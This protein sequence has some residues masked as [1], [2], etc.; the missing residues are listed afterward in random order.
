MKRSNLAFS[1]PRWLKILFIASIMIHLSFWCSI[2]AHF[3]RGTTISGAPLILNGQGWDY[4]FN[5]TTYRAGPASDFFQIVQ[6]GRDLRDGKSIYRSRGSFTANRVVPYNYKNHYPPFAALVIGIPASL[7]PCW[8]AYALWLIILEFCWLIS[9]WIL[10]QRIP[11][12]IH[13][14]SAWSLALLFTPAYPELFFGQT[15]M[16]LMFIFTI[17]LL[18]DKIGCLTLQ[19][20]ACIT[21]AAMKLIPLLLVPVFLRLRRFYQTVVFVL[22]TACSAAWYFMLYPNDFKVFY[23]WAIGPVSPDCFHPGNVGFQTLLFHS[24]L[25]LCTTKVALAITQTIALLPIFLSLSTLLHK[26]ILLEYQLALWLATYLVA[27]KHVWIHHL[28]LALPVLMILIVAKP[29]RKMIWIIFIMLA[30]PTPFP[31]FNYLWPG[32]DGSGW[33]KSIRI[34]ESALKACPVLLLYRETYILSTRTS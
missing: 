20:I 14:Y 18:C 6:S 17:I 29:R 10:G 27:Y 2:A 16:F 15:S 11:D 32:C 23:S 13:R 25:F 7:I 33:P 9:L 22:A 26:S 8:T 19:T 3:L 4:F 31:L 21:G 30:L 34:L 24:C 1:K 5:G 12:T 28:V